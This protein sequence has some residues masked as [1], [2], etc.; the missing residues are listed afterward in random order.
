MRFVGAGIS[1]YFEKSEAGRWP[2]IADGLRLSL[3]KLGEPTTSRVMAKNTSRDGRTPTQRMLKVG[4]MIRRDLSAILQRG[5]VHDPDLARFM[6]TVG[7]VRMSPDLRIA[8]AFILPLGGNQKEEALAAVRR[9]RH[10]IR[11]LVVKGGTMKHA[12]EIRF[13]IDGTFD[14]MDATRALLAED[15]VKQDLDD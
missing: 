12:P 2:A 3:A 5:E 10:E 15:H 14:Q 11:H 9:N 7:E 13:E 6:L 4:E 1:E 8:T